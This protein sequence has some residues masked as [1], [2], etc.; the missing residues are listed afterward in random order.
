MIEKLVGINLLHPFGHR[1]G[2]QQNRKEDEC[3]KRADENMRKSEVSNEGKSHCHT[4]EEQAM[5]AG[6]V[7][8]KS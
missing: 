5:R 4:T 2:E 6:L 3:T 8:F 7:K 1:K